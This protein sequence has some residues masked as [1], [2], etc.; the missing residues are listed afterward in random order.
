MLEIKKNSRPQKLRTFGPEHRICLVCELPVKCVYKSAQKSYYFLLRNLN[1]LIENISH[2][3]ETNERMIECDDHTSYSRFAAKF[4]TK[5]TQNP[6]CLNQFKLRRN[7][8]ANPAK[9]EK[10]TKLGT[11]LESRYHF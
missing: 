9:T 1:H 10:L 5:I 8:A 2:R 3:V 11:T 4:P 7:I 6:K